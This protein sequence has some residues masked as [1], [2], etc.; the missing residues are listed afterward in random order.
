M[1]SFAQY[2]NVC[3]AAYTDFNNLIKAFLQHP[4]EQTRN[5]EIYNH[6]DELQ[7][8]INEIH[9]SKEERYKLNSLQADIGVVKKFIAPISNKYNAHL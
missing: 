1:K 3:D 2:N 9:V 6:L 8:I 5:E 4:T 7:N